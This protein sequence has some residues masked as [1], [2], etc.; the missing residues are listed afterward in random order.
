MLKMFEGNLLE[1]VN[2]ELYEDIRPLARIVDRYL[3]P[4]TFFSGS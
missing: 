1:D 3:F 4:L 2:T